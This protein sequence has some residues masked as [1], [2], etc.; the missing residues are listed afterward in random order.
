MLVDLKE[1]AKEFDQSLRTIQNWCKDAKVKKIANEFQLTNDIVDEWRITK[2]KDKTKVKTQPNN[3]SVAPAKRKIKSEIFTYIAL[4][5]VTALIG[6]VIYQAIKT[7]DQADD[8]KKKD[9]TI[10][11]Q[12]TIIQ[13]KENQLDAKQSIIEGLKRQHSIDSTL[14]NSPVYSKRKPFN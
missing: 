1:V 14:I 7:S 4:V 3:K 2:L 8:I 6:V 9:N 12:Q 11:A 13:D 5:F 10:Q